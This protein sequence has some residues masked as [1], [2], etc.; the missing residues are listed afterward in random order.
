M[1]IIVIT[2]KGIP[3]KGVGGR[4]RGQLVDLVAY[5]EFIFFEVIKLVIPT[6][7]N[8]SCSTLRQLA[9]ANRQPHLEHVPRIL[10]GVHLRRGKLTS[11]LC[12]NVA[13]TR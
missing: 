6:L 2:L 5:Y 12:E 8:H 4:R 10:S 9:Q 3:N 13:R 7:Q 1:M 11:L